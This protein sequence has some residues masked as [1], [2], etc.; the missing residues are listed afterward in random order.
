[1]IFKHRNTGRNCSVRTRDYVVVTLRKVLRCFCQESMTFFS[2]KTIINRSKWMIE[3]YVCF[4]GRYST[5]NLATSPQHPPCADVAITI[6]S[7]SAGFIW[8]PIFLTKFCL[9]STPIKCSI[10]LLRPF[11]APSTEHPLFASRCALRRA[12]ELLCLRL[13]CTMYLCAGCGRQPIETAQSSCLHP[14][15]HATIDTGHSLWFCSQG[16]W[17]S[18]SWGGGFVSVLKLLIIL[19]FSHLWQNH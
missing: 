16:I 17:E 1:M 12:A 7:R 2:P 11:P 9:S 8:T 10:H 19:L 13:T 6:W 18:Y 14:S 5:W 3:I 4:S 15:L